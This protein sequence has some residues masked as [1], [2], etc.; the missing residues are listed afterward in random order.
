MS[1]SAVFSFTPLS[2]FTSVK[3]S[4]TMRFSRSISLFTSVRNSFVMA[5]S[6]GS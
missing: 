6:I 5:G 3:R 1:S 2:M 4:E